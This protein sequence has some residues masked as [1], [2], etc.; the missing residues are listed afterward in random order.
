MSREGQWVFSAWEGDQTYSNRKGRRVNNRET[1]K[2]AGCYL[3]KGSFGRKK[4]R[5]ALAKPPVP[6]R[7]LVLSTGKEKY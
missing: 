5:F 6:R 4:R 2:G 1:K 3:K 7:R